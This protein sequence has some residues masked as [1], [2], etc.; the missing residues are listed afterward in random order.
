[1]LYSAGMDVRA[2]LATWFAAAT[3]V[4]Y[5]F[6]V[7]GD[8]VDDAG[9]TYRFAR[10]LA[11]GEGLC[12]NP[13]VRVEGYVHFLWIA[14]LAAVEWVT[15]VAPMTA[16]PLLGRLFGALAVVATGDLAAR[17]LPGSRWA[18]AAPWLLATNLYFA[19]WSQA[20]LETPLFV[21]LALATA[22]LAL[23]GGRAARYGAPLVAVAM[24]MT[25][26]EG[27]LF[28]AVLAF[29]ALRRHGLG[30]ATATAA[31]V[32]LVPAI[33]YFAWRWSY[34]GDLLPN[35][36]Y[37]KG[38]LA[39]WAGFVYVGRFVTRVEPRIVLPAVVSIVVLGVTVAA[40]VPALPA[41][42]RS[43][44]RGVLLGL[45]A[46]IA[47]V[48]YEGGDWMG[49]FRFLVP[50]LPLFAL[51]AACAAAHIKRPTAIAL[52]AVPLAFNAVNGT[53]Y[54]LHAPTDPARTWFH[55]R[56]YYDD[57]AA[58]VNEHVEPGTLCA[59]GDM[60]YVPYHSLDVRY[61]DFLGLVDRTIAHL[62]GGVTNPEVYR[63]L[64]S[65]EP[66]WFFSLVHHLP[67]GTRRGHTPVDATMLRFLDP[68]MPP[69]HRLFRFHCEV[70][71]WLEHGERV[72]FY[73]YRRAE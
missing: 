73:V 46:W 41:V 65:R 56:D 66:V 4:G 69:E 58:W 30:R 42:W 38:G 8:P 9:I 47:G 53:A 21:W 2:R 13:G 20:G 26:P 32:F 43:R 36:F 40:V 48:F 55:Q 37:A 28:V 6:A 17:L 63:Y 31:T 51:L 10:N 68:A 39:W 27:V 23:R 15:G 34:F 3:L 71:G 59:L 50:T 57:M 18:I 12:F 64:L 70:P 22:S 5:S 33:G 44:A 60:G 54:A 35:V 19:L 72:A 1:M 62:P 52:V 7:G 25:R 24:C 61:I 16:G 14:L 49:G 45:G 67:D 29:E 11:A